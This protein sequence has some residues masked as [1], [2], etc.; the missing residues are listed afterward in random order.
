MTISEAD[1]A[2][3]SLQESAQATEEARKVSIVGT[4]C[5]EYDVVRVLGEGGMGYVYEGLQPMIGKRVA[6]KVLK[7][8][9]AWNPEQMQRLL[10]EA[11]AV[12][13]VRH[14]GIIDIFS[15]GELPDRRQYLVMELLEGF[16]LDQSL[17][18]PTPLDLAETLSIL[19]EV[20]DALGA[21][22]RVGVVHRDL[23]PSNI[24]I[25]AP[26][27]SVRYVKLLDFG[28][29]KQAALPGGTTPQTRASMMIGTPNY[30][31]PEQA[32][33][34][35]V[36]PATDL[37][38]LGVLAFEM[39]TRALPFD[40][41]SPFEIIYKHLHEPPPKPSSLNPAVPPELDALVLRLLS[42]A[43]SDRPQTAEEVRDRVRAIA[44]LPPRPVARPS[45]PNLQAVSLPPVQMDPT[46]ISMR[47]YTPGQPSAAADA[48]VSAP[49]ASLA[50]PAV[51]AVTPAPR[52][53]SR[54][55]LVV[56]AIAAAVLL[57]GSAAW[58]S[59]RGPEPA[60]VQATMPAPIAPPV[61]AS[62]QVAPPTPVAPTV[63]AAAQPAPSPAPPA[64]SGASLSVT[65][66][67][68]CELSIDGRAR[69]RAP[70]TLPDL[71]PGPHALKCRNAFGAEAQAQVDLQPGTASTH[72]FAF[73]SGLLDVW[74]IPFAEVTIDGKRYGE[75]PIKA[76]SLVE[77]S[78]KVELT[79]DAQ[80]VTRSVVITGDAP[81]KLKVNME[82]P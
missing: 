37:Y 44:G 60:S 12:N 25:V 77:G 76:V 32:R 56:G 69:G 72:G 38:A 33:G 43:P 23:K 75:T 39:L 46:H 54:R 65:S 35:A 49:T 6:I 17:S 63:V 47:S 18:Q 70:A 62:A 20:L 40:G 14:R 59:L 26:E 51:S 57:A 30:M 42:K 71:A 31:A 61:P 64:P 9:I 78:H 11:R 7:S 80:R 81:V 68:P 79:M 45:S 19:D 50:A 8:E 24:F 41:P 27:H 73:R 4:K 74:V 34:E 58:L 36:G 48:S 10:A 2:A 29:A 52:T 21:A 66:N 82:A 28:L 15:F 5:G 1:K 67:A 16:P 55:G 13:A 22:H 53:A 3:A